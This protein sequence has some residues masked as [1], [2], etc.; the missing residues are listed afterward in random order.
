[1]TSPVFLSR[2]NIYYD[3]S[4][5]DQNQ[6]HF[7]EVY[8]M[9]RKLFTALLTGVMVIS[10]TT[11][12]FAGASIKMFYNGREIQSNASPININ[13]RVYAPVRALA[14]A[15]GANVAWDKDSSQVQI[16][17]NDQSMQIMRLESALS[18][19]DNLDAVNSW[20]EAVQNRNGAW[21]YAL[22]TP[23]LKKANYDNFTSMNWCTGVSSPWVKGFEVKE[24]GKMDDKTVRYSVKFTWTD[25]T[26]TTSATT[27]YVTVK[28]TDGVWLIGA[29]DNLSVRGKITK[30]NYAS[31]KDVE[32]VFV[33]SDE[34]T[35]A[36]YQQATVII[37]AETKIY[38]GNT[39][40]EL[41][42]E[43]LK[44][45]SSVEAVFGSDPMIMIYPPQ[46]IAKEIRVF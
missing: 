28:N 37:G 5:K 1:M 34:S 12:A 42:P 15:M 44:L 18:P 32:S 6:R 26:N 33:E 45:G 31:A 39:N 8:R 43:D 7:K 21:Q 46:A 22:M 3:T 14:E 11:A 20:A 4:S 40:I 24:L 10:L 38:K 17:G 30:V 9:K 29:I 2:G 27:Q 36:M 23:D 16:T 41:K 35:E 25:S 13:G 19:R